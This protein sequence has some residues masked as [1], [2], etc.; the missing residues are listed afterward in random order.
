MNI[1]IPDHVVFRDENGTAEL[2]MC[3][4]IKVMLYTSIKMKAICSSGEFDKCHECGMYL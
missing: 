3:C 2:C 4:A 1:D